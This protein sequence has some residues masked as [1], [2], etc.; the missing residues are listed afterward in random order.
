MNRSP[1]QGLSHMFP[2]LLY[3]YFFL[4]LNMTLTT[5]SAAT[6]NF[7]LGDSSEQWRFPGARARLLGFNLAL[8]F[9][10]L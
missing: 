7:P 10:S 8:P 9:P 1:Y 4:F 6:S 3:N 2:L 5:P